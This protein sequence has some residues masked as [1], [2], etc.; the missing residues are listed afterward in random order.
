MTDCIRAVGQPQCK[1]AISLLPEDVR[2]KLACD[3]EEWQR[4][5]LQRLEAMYNVRPN[6]T[7]WRTPIEPHGHRRFDAMLPASRHACSLSSFGRG[8]GAKLLCGLERQ[9]KCT[10]ISIGSRG[11][12]NFERDVVKRTSCNVHI[13]DCTVSRC[14]KRV[15]GSWPPEMR[16]GRV[17][18]H[19]VCID[20]T[21]HVETSKRIR[22]D[23]RHSSGN[24]TFRSYDSI[25]AKLG[26]AS[27]SAMKM[28]IEG[29]E[30]NVLSDMLRARS[31]ALPAQI[32][33]ELHWQTQMTSL[34]WHHRARTA[35]EIA[36]FARA[37]YDAGYR[38]LSR[39]DNTRCPHCSEFNVMRIFCPPPQKRTDGA[40]GA[41]RAAPLLLAPTPN[42]EDAAAGW[43][44]SDPG[45]DCRTTR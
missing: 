2:Q 11:D 18:F 9:P 22:G 30:Y 44:P 12:I 28:D 14:A 10:I 36:L 33:F 27:V 17:R 4:S 43:G 45:S 41:S 1:A 38:A 20:A 7:D 23:W 24:F 31:T 29:F 8:D 21:D 26:L 13:F 5:L 34:A 15:Q 35:G 6:G 3:G 39:S 16:T 37:L 32:A 40:V 19:Q 25:V 42:A